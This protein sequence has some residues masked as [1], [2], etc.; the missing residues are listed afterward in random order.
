MQKT[1]LAQRDQLTCGHVTDLPEAGVVVVMVT[2]QFPDV[3]VAATVPHSG[4]S[5]TRAT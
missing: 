1:E 3:V 5:K 4:S 2:T